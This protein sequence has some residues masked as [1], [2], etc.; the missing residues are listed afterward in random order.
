MG[1]ELRIDAALADAAGD[2]LGVLA[3]EI[4]YEDGAFLRRRLGE[5]DDDGVGHHPVTF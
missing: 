5:L 3:A 2:E 4:H 1:D